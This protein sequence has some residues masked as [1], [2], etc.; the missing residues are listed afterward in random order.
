MAQDKRL[1]ILRRIFRS[2]STVHK[3]LNELTSLLP[4]NEDVKDSWWY[5]WMI[6]DAS[7]SLGYGEDSLIRVKER[8]KNEKTKRNTT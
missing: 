3:N 1:V 4:P 7:Y 6:E 5:R 2:L 8:M